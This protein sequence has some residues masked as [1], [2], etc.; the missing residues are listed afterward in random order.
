MP[1][2][3]MLVSAAVVTMFIIFAVALIWGE[4]QSRSL[5]QEPAGSPRKRRSF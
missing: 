3:S 1:I 2:D 5:R 4:R